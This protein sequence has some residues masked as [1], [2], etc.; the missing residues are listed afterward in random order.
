MEAIIQTLTLA[1]TLLIM[2]LSC[3]VVGIAG[4]IWSTGRER[5]RIEKQ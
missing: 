2:G 1:I 3:M 4:L 5:R